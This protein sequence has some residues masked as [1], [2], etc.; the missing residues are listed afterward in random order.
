MCLELDKNYSGD[1]QGFTS[2]F[3]KAFNCGVPFD[4]IREQEKI[5][6]EKDIQGELTRLSIEMREDFEKNFPKGK[7]G[8]S[9]PRKR[10]LFYKVFWILFKGKEG[11]MEIIESIVDNLKRYISENNTESYK[12]RSSRLTVGEGTQKSPEPAT[13]ESVVESPRV[14][15][16]NPEQ[17]EEELSALLSAPLKLEGAWNPEINF[18]TKGYRTRRRFAAEKWEKK[19]W[20]TNSRKLP[21]IQ[22]HRIGENWILVKT[23]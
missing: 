23:N 4:K 2:L 18:K 5:I 12:L 7:F 9:S 22:N 13:G 14:L 16:E 11:G 15:R 10:E 8:L 1:W 17:T 19:Q 3:R 6:E 20:P 21:L